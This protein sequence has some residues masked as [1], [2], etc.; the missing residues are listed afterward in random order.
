MQVV[1]AYDAVFTLLDGDRRRIGGVGHCSADIVSEAVGGSRSTNL[2][3]LDDDVLWHRVRGSVRPT[4]LDDAAILAPVVQARGCDRIDTFD[5]RQF[6][7][8]P[9]HARECDRLSC[10]PLPAVYPLFLVWRGSV[11]NP[12]RISGLQLRKRDSTDLCIGLAWADVIGRREGGVGQGPGNECDKSPSKRSKHKH[13]SNSR[14]RSQ[15][16]HERGSF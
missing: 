16:L 3:L 6:P 15:Q 5:N 9:R 11:V 7:I 10:G 4:D 13:L 8:G 1:V 14:L 2:E 12:V